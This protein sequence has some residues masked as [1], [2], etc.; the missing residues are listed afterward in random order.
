MRCD[1]VSRATSTSSTTLLVVRS[2][3]CVV[4][5]GQKYQ[6][7]DPASSSTPVVVVSRH[8]EG[9]PVWANSNSLYLSSRERE[10]YSRSS[11]SK[12]LYMYYSLVDLLLV[13]LV[14]L[15]LWPSTLSLGE[16]IHDM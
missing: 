12:Y 9:A 7:S 13:D 15:L 10:A 4:V 16:Y 14:G 11:R 3:T 6:V 5:C 8:C 2:S 1:D